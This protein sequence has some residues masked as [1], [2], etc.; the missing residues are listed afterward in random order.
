MRAKGPC[1][2]EPKWLLAERGENGD[3][4]DDDDEGEEEG[5]SRGCL[6]RSAHV[7][8]RRP[9]IHS[10]ASQFGEG[11]FVCILIVIIIS[12]SSITC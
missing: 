4:D 7:H 1:G 9:K 3:D 5:G 11:V 12:S 10:P 8:M 2:P 6:K